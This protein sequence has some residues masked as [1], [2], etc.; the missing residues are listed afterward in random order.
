MVRFVM[1]FFLLLGVLSCI[2]ALYF[3]SYVRFIWLEI[4]TTDQDDF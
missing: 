3:I 4:Y 2:S 1:A